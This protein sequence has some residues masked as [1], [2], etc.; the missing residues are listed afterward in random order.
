MSSFPVNLANS[1]GP[2]YQ[3]RSMDLSI[4]PQLQIFNPI[5]RV[6]DREPIFHVFPL[7]T[8]ELRLKIWEHALYDRQRLLRVQLYDSSGENEEVNS[9]LPLETATSNQIGQCVTTPPFIYTIVV[10]GYKSL[11]KF[12]R[13]NQ[14]A[15]TEALR[16]YRVKIPCRLMCDPHDSGQQTVAMERSKPGFLYFNP[17]SDFLH[18]DNNNALRASDDSVIDHSLIDFIHKLKNKYDPKRVGLL[19]LLFGGGSSVGFQYIDLGSDSKAT[20]SFR[21]TMQQLRKIHFLIEPRAGRLNFRWFYG[22]DSE[23]F[24]T[25]SFPILPSTSSFEHPQHRDPRP[26]AEELKRIRFGVTEPRDTPATWSRLL[27]KWSVGLNSQREHKYL[28]TLR[29]D[30]ARF[31]IHD[32]ESAVDYLQWEDHAWKHPDAGEFMFGDEDLEKAIQPAFGFWLFDMK[33]FGPFTDEGDIVGP[34]AR[35]YAIWD[36]TDHWPSLCRSSTI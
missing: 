13:V 30:A 18:L 7:L 28:V 34:E 32:R 8:T 6:R 29:P 2:L 33:T 21:A 19:N 9:R 20:A 5:P 15:R 22:M 12:M 10:E 23:T 3:N 31:G 26:I 24:F 36:L 1:A 27:R 4:Q 14:E 25:R 17:E 16:F 11:S 35:G